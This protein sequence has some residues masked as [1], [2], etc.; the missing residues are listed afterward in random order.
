MPIPKKE[1]MASLHKSRKEAGLVKKSFWLTPKEF[2]KVSAYV[3]KVKKSNLS[4]N[5][6]V[7]GDNGTS[8]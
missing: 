8:N 4:R 6:P 3:E 1:L 5:T 7:S 2:V